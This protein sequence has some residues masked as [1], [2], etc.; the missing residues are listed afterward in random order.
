MYNDQYQKTVYNRKE[1]KRRLRLCWTLGRSEL[2]C[3]SCYFSY[4]PYAE[5]P[6][7]WKGV[8]KLRKKVSSSIMS[9]SIKEILSCVLQSNRRTDNTR[10]LQSDKSL[11]IDTHIIPKTPKKLDQ[12]GKHRPYTTIYGIY[13]YNSE[14][15]EK[16][17]SRRGTQAIHHNLRNNTDILK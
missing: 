16:T 1:T 13:R 12:E 2:L 8:K 9:S 14:N 4:H 11:S 6:T 5:N 17:W 15:H 10:V 3:S 7:S